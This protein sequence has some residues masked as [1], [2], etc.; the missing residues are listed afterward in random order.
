MASTVVKDGLSGSS[1][2][3][4]AVVVARFNEHIT[5][6]LLE[7]AQRAAEA[8]GVGSV[9]VFE[10]PGSFELP[11]V[12]Q[13]LADSDRFD[14]VVCL[15]AVVRHE[16]DHYTHVATQAARGIMEVSL[17]T[18]VPCLF[19]VLTCDSDEQALARAG[20]PGERN[21]GEEAMRSAIETALV[22]RA[23]EGP[24]A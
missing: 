16:T 5:S 22:L 3:S 4:I 15:G 19:G 7:G 12:A 20:G 18:G 2:L 17:D 14:A 6:R 1:D 11:V 13:A 24:R 10:V 8:E 21:A 9:E 23:V